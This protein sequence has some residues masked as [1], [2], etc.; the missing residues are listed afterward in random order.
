MAP[1]EIG[2]ETAASEINTWKERRP[3]SYGFSHQIIGNAETRT[4]LVD[5]NQPGPQGIEHVRLYTMLRGLDRYRLTCTTSEPLF[6]KYMD[7]CHR[8][9]LS[10]YPTTTTP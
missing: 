6:K 7:T 5:F 9:A 10:L 2:D 8:I 4:I 3:L 1:N